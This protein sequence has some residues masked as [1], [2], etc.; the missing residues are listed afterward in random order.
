MILC[1][2]SS[3]KLWHDA[4]KQT[5]ENPESHIF[6][7]FRAYKYNLTKG[8]VKFYFDFRERKMSFNE[9][10]NLDYTLKY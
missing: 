9:I 6:E 5:R 10:L 3:L 7:D 2:E 4:G 8:E 1:D